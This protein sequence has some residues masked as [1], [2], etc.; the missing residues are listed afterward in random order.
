MWC[1]AALRLSDS[2]C[3]QSSTVAAITVAAINC[4]ERGAEGCET[5]LTSAA[6]ERHM[7]RFIQQTEGVAWLAPAG[8]MAWGWDGPGNTRR[9]AHRTS[10]RS[11]S[12]GDTAEQ[13]QAVQECL[14]LLVAVVLDC[15]H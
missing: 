11:S 2:S 9:T 12:L 1:G 7:C 5:V 3:V 8:C 6:V 10:C 13:C 15:R 4:C 14:H